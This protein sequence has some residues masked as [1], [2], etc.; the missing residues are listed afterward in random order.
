MQ[1]TQM[2]PRKKERSWRYD[3]RLPLL[4]VKLDLVLL[5]ILLLSRLV[6]A[7]FPAS[8]AGEAVSTRPWYS[9]FGYCLSKVFLK[10]SSLLT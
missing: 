6:L 5:A 2:R 8:A 4:L 7:L 10:K 3:L 1:E 9:Q